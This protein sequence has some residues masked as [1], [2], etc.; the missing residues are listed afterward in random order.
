MFRGRCS[1]EE[2]TLPRVTSKAAK[3][4]LLFVIG[5]YKYVFRYAYVCGGQRKTPTHCHPSRS[6]PSYFLSQ[7]V[8]DPKLTQKP[9]LPKDQVT[10]WNAGSCSCWK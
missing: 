7:A 5:V 2:D 6:G 1:E 8:L 3:C 10:P 4:V 9:Q